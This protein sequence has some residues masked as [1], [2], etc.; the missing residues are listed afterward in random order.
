VAILHR[1]RQADANGDGQLSRAEAPGLIKKYFAKL[2][3]NDDGL[4]A[5]NEIKRAAPILRKL[6]QAHGGKKK[7]HHKARKSGKPAGKKSG[8]PGKKKHRDR[9]EDLDD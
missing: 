5:P 6:A 2:D 3:K 1:L 8:K 4:L 7:A 9:V